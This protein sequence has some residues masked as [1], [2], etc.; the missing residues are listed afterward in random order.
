MPRCLLG[1]NRDILHLYMTFSG[2]YILRKVGHFVWSPPKN[3]FKKTYVPIHLFGHNIFNFHLNILLIL[4]KFLWNHWLCCWKSNKLSMSLW[5]YFSFFFVS[6][7]FNY[8]HVSSHLL[9]VFTMRYQKG[10]T[11]FL[12]TTKNNCG[13]LFILYYYSCNGLLYVNA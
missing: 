7:W 2:V 11:Y 9:V 5:W 4:Q 6:N 13:F 3:T 10:M 12:R 8:V 1:Y